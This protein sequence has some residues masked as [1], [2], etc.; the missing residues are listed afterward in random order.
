MPRNARHWTGR[1]RI[2]TG[3]RAFQHIHQL[4]SGTYRIA[5]KDPIRS[6]ACDRDSHRT[7]TARTP[8]MAVV[9]DIGPGI[10][11]SAPFML[12]RRRSVWP[13]RMIQDRASLAPRKICGRRQGGNVTYACLGWGPT[14]DTWRCYGVR[15][16]SWLWHCFLVNGKT[17]GTDDTGPGGGMAI[18]ILLP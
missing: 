4:I 6:K 2:S 9:A 8:F 15:E 13:R 5:T 12:R 11:C 1:L 3:Y 10:Y 7:D 14:C 16:L 18:P 17:E